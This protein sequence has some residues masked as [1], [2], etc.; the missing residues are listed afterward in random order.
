M[1]GVRSSA[2]LVAIAFVAASFLCVGTPLFAASESIYLAPTQ[3]LQAFETYTVPMYFSGTSVL[4]AAEIEILVDETR[5]E[6]LDLTLNPA[7]CDAE[8]LL[9]DIV[10]PEFGIAYVACGSPTPLVV[11][12]ATTTI[13]YLTF[14]P[15]VAGESAIQFGTHTNLHIHDGTGA[16]VVA[17]TVDAAVLTI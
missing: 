11:A 1:T 6:L 14:R 2:F 9:Q 12:D 10:L 3:P 15:L 8:F 7:L 17:D 4:N 16:P 5:I 13:G